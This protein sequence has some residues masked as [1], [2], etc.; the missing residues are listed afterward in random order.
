VGLTRLVYRRAVCD[1]MHTARVTYCVLL[2]GVSVVCTRAKL[3]DEQSYRPVPD[4]P[5][6]ECMQLEPITINANSLRRCTEAGHETVKHAREGG[7]IEPRVALHA[8]R[9]IENDAV[10]SGEA[11]LIERHDFEYDA[12]V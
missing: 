6:N 12:R 8:R 5:L 11:I 10:D 9:A 7:S 4:T 2:L 3:L 1:R